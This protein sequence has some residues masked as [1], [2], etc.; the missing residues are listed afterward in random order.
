MAF[1]RWIWYSKC[2]LALAKQKKKQTIRA[3]H[4]LLFQLPSICVCF[5]PSFFL[6]CLYGTINAT[7]Q[8]DGFDI[9]FQ[10]KNENGFV[11]KA[12][13]MIIKFINDF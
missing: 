9:Y 12:K 3:W 2:N 11:S 5:F 6:L 1:H 7:Q 4:R 10:N 8:L 13:Q